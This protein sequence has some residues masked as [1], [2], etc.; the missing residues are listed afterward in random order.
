MWLVAIEGGKRKT[1][2]PL[3]HAENIFFISIWIFDYRSTYV[4]IKTDGKD[5]IRCFW[6]DTVRNEEEVGRKLDNKWWRRNSEKENWSSL[7]SW[8]GWTTS[9]RHTASTALKGSG[10]EQSTRSAKDKLER[11]GQE[12][13][14][15]LG[16]TWEEGEAAALLRQ[17]WRRSVA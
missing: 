16:L 13:C 14:R 6:K 15:W 8:Y 11:H 1:R 2:A 7:V 17:E 9:A 12:R 3:W 5:R 10:I 4:M